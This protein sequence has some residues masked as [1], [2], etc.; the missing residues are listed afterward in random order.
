[1][2]ESDSNDKLTWKEDERAPPPFKKEESVPTTSTTEESDEMS[3]REVAER[4][5]KILPNEGN[6]RREYGPRKSS[7]KRRWEV[8]ESSASFPFPREQQVPSSEEE[9]ESEDSCCNHE[10]PAIQKKTKRVEKRE[11]KDSS[12][13]EEEQSR[14]PLRPS[15][16]EFVTFTPSGV[17]LSGK[18]APIHNKPVS[19]RRFNLLEASTAISATKVGKKK[20]KKSRKLD[21]KESD[22]WFRLQPQKKR[23]NNRRN[24]KGPTPEELAAKEAARREIASLLASAAAFADKAF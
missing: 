20:K 16:K 8:V 11:R 17:L 14:R 24:C 13:E 21:R 22:N 9:T 6:N 10:K 2:N 15:D 18:L 12:S 19:S 23:L 4:R 5:S 1:M 7:M 3:D